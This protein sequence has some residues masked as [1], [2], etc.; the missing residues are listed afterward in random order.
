MCT[1]FDEMA[2]T[3]RVPRKQVRV[4][5]DVGSCEPA[6]LS[7]EFFKWWNYER[8]MTRRRTSEEK[9]QHRLISF[10]TQTILW[11]KTAENKKKNTVKNWYRYIAKGG[12]TE[13]KRWIHIPYG[14]LLCT[15]RWIDRNVC[16]SAKRAQQST[17]TQTHRREI[18]STHTAPKMKD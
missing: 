17:Y 14:S 11:T 1:L 18:A 10:S 15:V 3:H 16:T 7:F 12:Q 2:S 6:F 5:Y 8:I 4:A 9:P 13:M